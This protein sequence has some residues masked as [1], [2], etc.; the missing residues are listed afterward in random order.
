MFVL[1]IEY[2]GESG[3]DVK[4]HT[5]CVVFDIPYVVCDI[6]YVVFEIPYVGFDIPDTNSVI[7]VLTLVV[8]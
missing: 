5:P 2:L 4:N 7:L 1:H 6:P 8:T 3:R